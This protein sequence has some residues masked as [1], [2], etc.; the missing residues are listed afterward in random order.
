MTESSCTLYEVFYPNEIYFDPEVA[1][2]IRS[3]DS[4]L[5]EVVT[6]F[7]IEVE[8]GANQGDPAAWQE[9]AK[10]MRTKV[11]PIF[12]KIHK[13]FQRMIGVFEGMNGNT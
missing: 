2:A 6:Q 4:M 11:Q 8:T 3:F 12:E 1:T 7:Q 13:D 10:S 9:T 5:L